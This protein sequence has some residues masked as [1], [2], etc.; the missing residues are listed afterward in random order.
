MT[1]AEA[2]RL[3]ELAATWKREAAG[4]REAKEPDADTAELRAL[5]AEGRAADLESEVC[6]MAD[7]CRVFPASVTSTP[8]GS[9]V[10]TARVLR[11][12]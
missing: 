5:D 9:H 2:E 10:G 12:Y 11:L 3:L 7:G 8:I 1:P 4:Y 6:A